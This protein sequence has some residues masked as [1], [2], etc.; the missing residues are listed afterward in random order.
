M[1]EE[2]ILPPFP[3]E[4]VTGAIKEDAI[5]FLLELGLPSR[6]A[7]SHL[8]RWGLMTEVTINKA[9]IARVRRDRGGVP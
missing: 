9:D 5:R 8:T 1:A 7:A 2:R 4:L 6:L 3:D